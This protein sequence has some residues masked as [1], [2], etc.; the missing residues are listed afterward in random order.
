MPPRKTSVKNGDRHWEAPEAAFA[1]SWG[2]SSAARCGG[3]ACSDPGT[4]PLIAQFL[5]AAKLPLSAKRTSRGG[6]LGIS[7]GLLP[8]C[9]TL[10]TDGRPADTSAPGPAAS[11]RAAAGRGGAVLPRTSVARSGQREGAAAMPMKGRFPVR[12]TLQYLSQGDVI[13][14]SSVKVMTVNYNTAGEPSEGARWARGGQRGSL[15]GASPSALYRV[16]LLSLPPRKFVFFNIPQ[17]QYKNPWVQI[18]LLRNMTPSPFLRF[19]LGRCRGA[20]EGSGQRRSALC[21]A[22]LGR[23]KAPWCVSAR[24]PVTCRL[25][26]V[27]VLPSLLKT[28][29]PVA[30]QKL[31]FH[32]VFLW[33]TLLQLLWR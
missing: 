20:A 32:S 30:E 31:F 27:A 17:I 11:F 15:L 8:S 24:L 13:F 18:M 6:L 16:V 23:G 3:S 21:T 19:Y 2:C 10:V 12:R 22:L 4:L 33:S 14:K 1:R 9:T 26:L 5:A 7:P 29:L 25:T 28:A